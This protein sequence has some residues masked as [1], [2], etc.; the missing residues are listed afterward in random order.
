MWKLF[1]KLLNTMT[2]WGWW[3]ESLYSLRLCLSV[4][5][6]TYKLWLAS[7]ASSLLGSSDLP[8]TTTAM[9]VCSGFWDL[10]SYLFFSELGTEPRA[11]R[12]LG[13]R[14]TTEPNPQPP[15]PNSYLIACMTRALAIKSFLYLTGRVF[16]L[17]KTCHSMYV[18]ICLNVCLSVLES[19]FQWYYLWFKF[20]SPKK[21]IDESTLTSDLT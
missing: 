9:H 1:S 6:R 8:F 10:N 21:V 11:L 14:S 13:K 12:L 2:P 18:W 5:P 4:S 17:Y 15:T 3:L 7:L 19:I 16:L 20:W